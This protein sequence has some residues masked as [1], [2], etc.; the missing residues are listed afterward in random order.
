MKPSRP[1]GVRLS[2]GEFRGRVL[3]VPK[4]ARPSEGRVREALFSIWGQR[5][6]GARLLDLFA[7]SG[8]VALESMGRGAM[9]AVAVEGNPQALETIEANANKLGKGL[10]EIRNMILPAGLA[11]LA[12]TGERFDLVFADPPYA[13]NAYTGLLE[14]IAPLLAEEGEVVIE[15]SARVHLATEAGGLV[16]IEERRYGETALSFY[17]SGAG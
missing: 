9:S 16:Q 15:H 10:I 7:G 3:A 14:G 6:E 8:A 13:F 4:G 12:E 1:S 2:G 5:L 17:R 11:R